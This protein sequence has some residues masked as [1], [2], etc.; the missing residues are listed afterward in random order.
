MLKFLI[1]SFLAAA[2][3]LSAVSAQSQR[4]TLYVNHGASGAFLSLGANYVPDLASHS[5]NNRARSTCVT[6][7][8]LF[9]D[10]VNYNSAGNYN[11]E[12]VFGNNYCVSFAGLGAAVSSLRFAG[13]ASDYRLP[14]LSLY[15]RIYFQ[16]AEEYTEVDLP[17]LSLNGRIAS[18]IVTGSPNQ[19]WTLYDRANYAGNAICIYPPVTSIYEPAF[20]YDTTIITVPHNTI[21]SVRRGCF[22]KVAEYKATQRGFQVVEAA[23]PAAEMT[24]EKMEEISQ[25]EAVIV[26]AKPDPLSK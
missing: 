15:A 25:K 1:S 9:Y 16:G 23:A 21:A 10:I 24:P 3:C 20:I 11:M 2:F 19:G 5:F 12:Y 6:G 18:L 7:V 22:G 4:V 26:Q 13:P 17:N 8:W 14:S